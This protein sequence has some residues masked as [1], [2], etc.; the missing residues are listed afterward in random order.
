LLRRRILGPLAP[1]GPGGAPRISAD[2]NLSL[3]S[4]ASHG[5]LGRGAGALALDVAADFAIGARG[6]RWTAPAGGLVAPAARLA[7][8]ALGLVDPA[9]S[10]LSPAAIEA[11]LTPT[12]PTH[13]R[14][15]EGQAPGLRVTALDGG[16]ALLRARGD[17]GDFAAD[18]VLAPDRGLVIVL[19]SNTG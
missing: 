9:R 3:Q 4:G 18:L 13:E 19:L 1:A 10:P 14:A 17:T 12:I 6:A 15:G 11:L 7:E 16:G 8:L 5:H 2:P